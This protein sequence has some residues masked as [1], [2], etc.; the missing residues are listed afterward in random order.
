MV[1]YMS[2]F[3]FI[4]SDS[5]RLNEEYFIKIKKRQQKLKRKQESN[6]KRGKIHRGF[7]DKH[8]EGY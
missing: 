4:M 6:F 3:K 5:D 1:I 7:E 8:Y 2:D